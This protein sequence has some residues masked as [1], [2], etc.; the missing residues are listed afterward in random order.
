MDADPC[1]L[2]HKQ[3]GHRSSPDVSLAAVSPLMLRLLH[4]QQV[5]WAVNGKIMFC[6]L[7]CISF[8]QSDFVHGKSFLYIL[9]VTQRRSIRT[10]PFNYEN[11]HQTCWLN[12]KNIPLK[13]IGVR[14]CYLI[15]QLFYY[16]SLAWRKK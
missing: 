7:S 1:P 10:E 15:V 5:V 3:P 16:E 13:S 9:K 14:A 6:A 11:T 8:L 4:R 12:A 2:E